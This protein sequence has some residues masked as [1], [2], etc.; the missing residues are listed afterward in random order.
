MQISLVAFLFLIPLVFTRALSSIERIVLLARQ[1]PQDGNETI[2]WVDI[3]HS[4]CNNENPRTGN[5]YS[6]DIANAWDEAIVLAKAIDSI[7]MTRDPGAFDYENTPDVYSSQ[8][9]LRHI[10]F[11]PGFQ[12]ENRAKEVLNVYNKMA[13]FGRT[14]LWGWRVNAF[15]QS[16]DQDLM[17]W[18]D[19]LG[20]RGVVAY[21]WDTFCGGGDAND[22]VSSY[23]NIMFCDNFFA[24]NS[25]DFAIEWG[26]GRSAYEKYNLE[27]Y[28]DNRGNPA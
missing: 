18:C 2:Q 13:T 16:E 6:I 19:P 1:E 26:K 17:R 25:L 20:D 12:T 4:G 10:V 3:K 21:E 14:P 15:C 27:T 28:W 8:A 5:R 9:K 22:P 11:G 24:K 7:N 23:I